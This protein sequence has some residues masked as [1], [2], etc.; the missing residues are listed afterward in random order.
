MTAPTTYQ[1]IGRWRL[2]GV[3]AFSEEQ[4]ELDRRRGRCTGL[5]ECCIEYYVGPW[6]A[7]VGNRFRDSAAATEFCIVHAQGVDY[8]ACPACR[9]GRSFVRPRRCRRE[10]CS[11][12]GWRR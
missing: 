2:Y 4:R 7:I 10:Y 3:L 8:I 5:P 9:A 12:G 1:A 11:C 6:M